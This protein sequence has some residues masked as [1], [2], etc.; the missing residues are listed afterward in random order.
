MAV[1]IQHTSNGNSIT[2]DFPPLDESLTLSVTSESYSTSSN[3]PVAAFRIYRLSGTSTISASDLDTID[4]TSSLDG[5]SSVD[6]TPSDTS[7]WFVTSNS[8]RYWTGCQRFSL[9]WMSLRCPLAQ[10]QN[11]LK[12]DIHVL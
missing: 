9:M 2:V 8:I 11:P 12:Y 10:I 4:S 3:L 1:I 5:M 7:G 6:C